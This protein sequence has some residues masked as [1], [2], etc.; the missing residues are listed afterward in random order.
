MINIPTQ[1][2]SVEEVS[3]TKP[4]EIQWNQIKLESRQDFFEIG[5]SKN[6]CLRSVGRYE[7]CGQRRLVDAMLCILADSSCSIYRNRKV[8]PVETRSIVVNGSRSP[9]TASSGVGDRGRRRGMAAVEAV[10][11][12]IGLIRVYR[13]YI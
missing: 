6:S 1:L 10:G 7:F 9:L 4:T 12:E 8:D 5:N 13:V 11:G 3:Y 2:L